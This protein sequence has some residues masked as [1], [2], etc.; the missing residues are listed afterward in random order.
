MDVMNYESYVVLL[1]CVPV[2][3]SVLEPFS[4]IGE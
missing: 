3:F 2:A 1:L 4:Q